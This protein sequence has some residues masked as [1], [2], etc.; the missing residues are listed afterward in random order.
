MEMKKR[1]TALEHIT[2]RTKNPGVGSW[3]VLAATVLVAMG[4]WSVGHVTKEMAFSDLV[5]PFNLLSFAGA[6]G[7]VLGAWMAD[8]PLRSHPEEPK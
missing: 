2:S 3:A 7:S 5:T 1:I 4:S 6:L 8:S